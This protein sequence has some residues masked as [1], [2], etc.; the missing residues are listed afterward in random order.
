MQNPY[1][2]LLSPIIRRGFVIRNRMGMSR[3]YPP[4]SAG[5]AAAEPLQNS[6]AFTESF[7]KNGAALVT[8]R[9]TRWQSRDD[10]PNGKPFPGFPPEEDDDEPDP[11]PIGGALDGP[12]AP[13]SM[14]GPDL[15]I[16]NVKLNYIHTAQAI[17]DQGSLAIMSLMEVEPSGWTI[18]EISAE[19]LARM[20]DDFAFRCRQYQALGYDGCGFYMCYRSSLLA[21]SLSPV[22][23]H[24]TDRYGT[25]EALALEAFQ[26]V[27]TACGSHFLIEIEVSGREPD[28]G[29]TV[30]DLCGYL[31]AWEPYI[32][33]VQVRAETVELAHPIGI[34]ST[35]DMPLTL[36]YAK[37][38]KESGTSLIIAPL[39]GFHDPA[40]NERF[41]REG[42]ADM[43]YMA[44]AFVSDSHYYDK[45]VSGHSDDIIPCIRC[46]KCH[47]KPA[48][49]NPGCSVN[50]LF[51]LQALPGFQE[52][53]GTEHPKKTAVVGGG[54]AG[55]QAAIT[56]ARLGH[57]VTLYEKAAQLGGQLIPA[58]TADFKWPVRE[59]KDYLI[60]QVEKAGV[61]V[62]LRT[63]ATPELLQ[64]GNFDAV[65]LAMGAV[66]ACPDI[67]GIEHAETAVS[68]YQDTERLGRR[69]VLVGGSES[70]LE[71]ALYLARTGRDVTLLT[72]QRQAAQDAHDVHYREILEEYWKAEPNLH[73]VTRA[74]TVEIGMDHVTYEKRGE[75]VTV[76]CDNVIISGGMTS[77][78]ADIAGFGVLTPHMHVIGD[79]KCVGDIRNA[80]RDG[81]TAACRL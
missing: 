8:C 44:R 71:T 1:P 35:P 43:I 37:Q 31:K 12:P 66:P 23:N 14:S 39:G 33:V 5:V 6:I 51:S 21:Q 72:R 78:Q 60:R 64:T 40:R 25:Y 54:P 55:M 52:P 49:P 19:A 58:G 77:C 30:A 79:C 53:K 11:L 70:G 57:Q 81:Y 28:G 18:D 7:A 16:A 10:N 61:A 9:S 3:A 48:E 15:S 36:A 76:C 38:L 68:V 56:A 62:R 2:A 41:L 17:H 63:A 32:D 50:P 45:L 73:I 46:N 59:L 22:L 65:I 67:P 20:T 26:K 75:T 13:G 80:I 4:F 24:R 34:S 29:Y 47:T 42:C 74:K 27:R 69:I